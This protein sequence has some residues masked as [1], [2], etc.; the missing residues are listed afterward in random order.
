MSFR[1]VIFAYILT[2]SL[3]RPKA[4]QCKYSDCIRLV[5]LFCFPQKPPITSAWQSV[6]VSV[7]VPRFWVNNRIQLQS[8]SLVAVLLLNNS[9]PDFQ[10]KCIG[11][12]FSSSILWKKN[13]SSILL[14]C[15]HSNWLILCYIFISFVAIIVHL[16][17]LVFSVL[18]IVIV[19]SKSNRTASNHV[20][21]GKFDL[22][23]AA[24]I[25][26][27]SIFRSFII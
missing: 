26:Y 12:S 25:V 20:L 15:A 24:C 11:F 1:Q 18:L 7:C 21:Y 16:A 19:Y 4:K 5:P 22:S 3:L 6:A 27:L 13:S 17:R 23:F 14:D 2:S 9:L 8:L 10:Y